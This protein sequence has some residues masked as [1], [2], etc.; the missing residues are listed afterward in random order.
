MKTR[1]LSEEDL[2]ACVPNDADALSAIENGFTWLIEGRVEMPP[3]MHF[4]VAARKEVDVKGAV[5]RGEPAFA[6][7]IA[8]GFYDNPARGLASCSSSFVI[9]DSE[10]GMTRA[11]CVDNG[12]LMDLRT[13]LAGA[14]SVK[15]MARKSASRLGVIGTGT[16]ARWQ[17]RC[18]NL[19]RPLTKVVAFGRNTDALAT[20]CAEMTQELGVPVEAAS[21]PAKVLSSTDMT[22]TT[23]PSKQPLVTANMIL[24]GHHITAMGSDMPGKRELAPNCLERADIIGC[25]DIDQ[26]L[27]NGELQQLSGQRDTVVP[28]GALTSGAV[29]LDRP[30]H[31]ISIC[32]LTGTGVQDTAIALLALDRAEEAGLG[33]LVN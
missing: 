22:V 12:Y 17:A 15:H 23:T 7:K 14:V 26:C 31:A 21:S 10:T 5:V 4:D 2:R 6:I 11:I 27:N 9:L 19:V 32:D 24:P 18:I 33:T 30:D 29:H 20:Y 8:S 28:L 13:G 1:I 16:Q 3:I 25:D